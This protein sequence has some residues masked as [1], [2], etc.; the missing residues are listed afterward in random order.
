MY[1]GRKL[2]SSRKIWKCEMKILLKS[3]FGGEM[4]WLSILWRIRTLGLE[5]YLFHF[6]DNKSFSHRNELTCPF[7]VR[8]RENE[9]KT[10]YSRTIKKHTQG[11]AEEEYLAGLHRSSGQTTYQRKRLPVTKSGLTAQVASHFCLR[12]ACGSL[13]EFSSYFHFSPYFP[14]TL[15]I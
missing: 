4:H 10:K 12:W 7:I 3:G 5:I 6:W 8:K 9:A 11:S 2:A 15:I 1:W 14:P 13:S